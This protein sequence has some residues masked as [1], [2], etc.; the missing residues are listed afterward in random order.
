M[1]KPLTLFFAGMLCL[2]FLYAQTSTL[3]LQTSE[4]NHQ[5]VQYDADKGSLMRFYATSNPMESRGQVS[6]YNS[7]ERRQ[8]LLQLIADNLKQLEQVEFD[9]MNING[10]VDYLLFKRNLEDEQY[11]LQQEQSNYGQIVRF[12]PFSDRI[13]TLAKPRARGVSVNAQE[14]AKEMDGILKAVMQANEK[15]KEAEGVEQHLATLASEAVK[16]LQGVLKSY[17]AFYNAYDPQFSWWIPK[18]Y[19]SLD[20]ELDSYAKGLLGK[21]KP[22]STQKDDG[23]GIIGRPIGREEL[24]RQLKLE[25]IPYTPEELTEIAN[26]EFAW[27][28][29]E[30]L[31]AS[32]EMGFG[33]DWKA[34]QEKVK[35]SF[36]APGQQPQAMLELYEQSVAFLK[37]YD[38][39]NISPIAEETW[40]VN[41]MS[42]ERQLVSPFFL[43]GESLIISYPTPTMSYDEK[44]MSMR[45]NNPHFSR[46]TVHHELIAGHH[47]QGFMNN[48]YKTYRNFGTPFWHEGNALYWE[49]ILWDMKFPRSPE[50]R[51][52][53]LFWRMHRCARIIFSLNYHMGIWKPQQ[54][55]DFLVDRVG[56]ERANAEGEVRRSFTGNYGPL[57]QLAY[58][59]GGLQFYALKKELVDT[60]KMSYKQYHDA[61]LQENALPVEMLRA[62]LI[63]QNLK[64]DFKTQ[65][66]FYDK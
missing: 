65:W 23:S 2:H 11:K 6:S 42:A 22:N 26:K 45:G 59:I 62:I 36:V 28:D 5:M 27:C 47:L 52:G 15:L 4:M 44:M 33:T 13:Y 14:V 20:S 51:I 61:I 43:G 12:L 58:M 29:A 32:K 39:V 57:Y 10:K 56:H 8:R 48:R 1:K 21:G 64:R 34:A 25:F 63:N 60:K 16:G 30:L 50:D 55:I 17:F 41:M 54:C 53:M 7:P 35:N 19:S 38:L 66:R 18:T 37:K 3:Y 49:F 24:I 9:K 40:R 31:K 46:A